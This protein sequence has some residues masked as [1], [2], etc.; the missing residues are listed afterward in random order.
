MRQMGK[1]EEYRKKRKFDRTP[2][3]SG[4][5]EQVSV[6]SKPPR[7]RILGAP[8]TSGE[9]DARWKASVKARPASREHGDTFVVQ[10][11]SATRLHYDFR[12]AVDGVLKSWAVPKGPSLNP[13][14]KRLAVQTED[15]PL[16]YGGFEGKIPEGNYGAGTVMVWDR[17]TFS[18]IGDADALRQIERGE[19][20]FHLNGE[21]LR[22]SFVLVKL[23]HGEK[24][25]EW[26][27]IKHKDSDVDTQWDMDVHD[28]SVLTG[29]TIEEIAEELPPRREPSVL[30]PAELEGARKGPMP[31]KS[32]LMLATTVER[33]FSDPDWLFEIKWDGVRTLARIED[34][35]VKLTSRN[36]IDVT[37]QYPE[38]AELPAALSA[39]EVILDGEIVALDE[40]GHSGF[41]R[42]QQRMHVRAPAPALVAQ[43]PVTYY[44]FDLLYCDGYD[45]RHVALFERKEFL[46]RLLHPADHVRFSDHQMEQGNE[47]YQLAGT[48]G[49]EGIIGKR[50]DS[51]YSEGRSN[52]WVKI[53]QTTTIDAVIGGW[54]EARTPG[55]RFGAL[56]LGLYEGKTLRFIGHVGTGFDG[57]AQEAIGKM[58]KERETTTCTFDKVPD[59]NEPAHWAKPELA[60]RVKYSEW[61]PDK[62]L[63]HPVFLG[64]RNDARPEE[65]T[66]KSEV[67]PEAK[68]DL[69]VAAANPNIVR[70]PEVVGKVLTARAQIE[71]ELFKGKAE[72]AVVEIDGKRMRWSNLNKVYW[73]ESG[74]TKRELLA[75]YYRMAEYVLPF[76]RN[77]PLVLRR[78]P[79]G[80]KGQSFFQKDVREGIP[81]WLETVA[82]ESEGKNGDVHY[83]VANDLASLLFLTSL[84]CIDHNP[85]SSRVD[86]L[87][88]PDYFFFDLDPSDE[89]E[90]SIVL[91][92]ARALNQRLDDIGVKAFLKTSGATGFH[93]YIP[94]QPVYT[95]AQLRTFGE[96]IARMVSAEHPKLVTHERIVAKR[97]KG[98]VLIDVQ[99]N[100]MG[101][102]LAAPYVVRAFPK[103][104][105]SAPVSPRELKANLVAQKFNIKTMAARVEEKGDLWSDFWTRR[106]RIEDVMDKLSATVA[107][108]KSQK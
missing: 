69:R 13:E 67:E 60:A 66:W 71:T 83:V 79:D 86:D 16:D 78:Y 76:L 73:P 40:K 25:N 98:R 7:K 105:V 84:G 100:S 36:G 95:Y 62:R 92:I 64:L 21:K 106:L 30:A 47:L 41:A 51:L 23:K 88:H 85:W 3:P 99:Q 22:G 87:E 57:Q 44:L 6:P 72:S 108:G 93:M 49:L 101:K 75:Y 55:L 35:S 5:E 26:L 96:V 12:L 4:D 48:N 81:D 104:P 80:I 103:A 20:K 102:P 68:S 46:R 56:L 70:V 59:T 9:E 2:E 63:R 29:R 77:R 50:A 65:L 39:R 42:L 34:G 8:Q 107:R 45:L 17:G 33:P 15:H 97:P 10:K 31:G 37:K 61:T 91:T 90:F 11:H 52:S 14:D 27:M 28:G 54:T 82:I 32:G 19:I 53:K 38:L 24:K 89:T 1:L 74:Y 43:V 94:V 18:P 58:L